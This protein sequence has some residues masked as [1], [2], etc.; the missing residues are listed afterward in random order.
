MLCDKCG[1]YQ[2]TTH[3]KSLINGELTEQHLCSNCAADLNFSFPNIFA[4][5]FAKNEELETIRCSCCGSSFADIKKEGKAGCS[6]CYS[7]FYEKL[8]PSLN[9]LHG[10]VKHIKSNEISKKESPT[11]I[12]NKKKLELK[13]AIEEENYEQ[14]ALLRDEIKILEGDKK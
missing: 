14:A 1:K 11:D 2:A 12:I 5:V 8:L 10:N 9:L 13:K 7:V 4:S 3:Y 6:Q